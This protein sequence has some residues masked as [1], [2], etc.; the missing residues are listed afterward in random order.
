MAKRNTRHHPIVGI[1][2]QR[3]RETR[4]KAHLTQQGLASLAKLSVSYVAR[5]ERGE[6]AAGVDV[7]A[8][9]AEALEITPGELLHTPQVP[10]VNLNAL[11]TRLKAKA[12]KLAER[13]DSAALQAATLVLSLIDKALER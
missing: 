10:I 11:K 2:A 12:A 5:L 7:L 8:Q 9:L 3:I 13:E 4:E 1:L 6:A